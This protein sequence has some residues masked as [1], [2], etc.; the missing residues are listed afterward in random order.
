MLK[1]EPF[2]K[3]LI[4]DGDYNQLYDPV[5]NVLLRKYTFMYI[6]HLIDNKIP[7]SLIFLDLDNFKQINDNYGHKSGDIVLKD[8]GEK[9]INYIGNKGIVGRYGGDEFIIIYL[10][11]TDYDTTYKFIKNMYDVE[12]ILRRKI[13][14]NNDNFFLTG[15]TGSVSYPKDA[16]S[17][18]SLLEKVDKAL[19]KGKQ[20]GRNCF[21]VYV[22][23]KHK[24]INTNYSLSTPLCYVYSKINEI[25]SLNSHLDFKMK[26]L[27]NYISKYLNTNFSVVLNDK[28]IYSPFD[29]TPV[30]KEEIYDKLNNY[31]LYFNNSFES[32]KKEFKNYKD[33]LIENHI[34]SILVCAIKNNRDEAYG[35]I[36]LF[37]TKIGRIWQEETMALMIYISNLIHAYNIR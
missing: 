23:E 2:F 10:E 32:L 15:T 13:Q 17:L 21:I 1:F 35:Y 22:E 28:L 18:E 8:I 12:K 31:G 30:L 6:N 11:A 24:N 27:S 29:N 14:I 19:Y 5:T 34:V 25:I 16:N 7:F 26:S 9:L 37:E 20:K 36:T 4:K 33:F 3:N